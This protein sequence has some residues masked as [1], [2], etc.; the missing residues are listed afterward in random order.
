M[1]G[2]C[3]N[4]PNGKFKIYVLHDIEIL[5]QKEKKKNHK[6]IPNSNYVAEVFRVRGSDAC[7]L[8]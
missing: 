1:A 6:Q 3:Q 5:P 4:V 8:I 2:I 7:H